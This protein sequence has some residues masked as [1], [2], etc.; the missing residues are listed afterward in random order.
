[1][2]GLE[3]LSSSLSSTKKFGKSLYTDPFK[4]LDFIL[5]FILFPKYSFKIFY[6]Y[7]YLSNCCC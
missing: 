4:W 1:M 3:Y 5:I 6:Q 7:N 2:K